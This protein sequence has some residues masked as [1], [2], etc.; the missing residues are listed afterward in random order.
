MTIELTDSGT[1]WTR[2]EFI[3][4]TLDRLNAEY[5]GERF[6]PY[7]WQFD[8]P[9]DLRQKYW[10][11]QAITQ[12]LAKARVSENL[13]VSWGAGARSDRC[14]ICRHAGITG[15][16]MTAVSALPSEHV[17]HEGAA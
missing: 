7:E 13:R 12:Y 6:F 8:L 10:A 16:I 9:T 15:A 11:L 1:V 3:Q 4:A 2:A 5:K 17:E 14:A